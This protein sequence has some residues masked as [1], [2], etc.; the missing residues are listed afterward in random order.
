MK[1]R[2]FVTLRAS[3]LDKEGRA[4]EKA[5]ENLGFDDIRSLRIGKL[6]DLETDE[7]TGR[8]EIVK[9]CD[10]LPVYDINEQYE[11]FEKEA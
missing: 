5:L 8:E 2:I 1:Y 6:I 10:T 4:V 9:I 11:I 7:A 3:V